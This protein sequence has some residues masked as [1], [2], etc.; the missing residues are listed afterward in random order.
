MSWLKAR[1]FTLESP[2][3]RPRYR[4]AAKACGH[5]H[6]T[7]AR[8]RTQ[9]ATSWGRSSLGRALRWHRRGSRFDPG[10]LHLKWGGRVG[11]A[12]WSPKPAPRG[13]TPRLLASIWSGCALASSL[14]WKASARRKACCGF[15]SRSLRGEGSNVNVTLTL[16]ALDRTDNA[17]LRS[18]LEHRVKVSSPETRPPSTTELRVGS[19]HQDSREYGGVPHFSSGRVGTLASPL[20]SKASAV[21]NGC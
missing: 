20:A 18:Q 11:C 8:I 4:R 7:F 16:C 5:C 15:D 1:S 2:D 6:P 19:A 13:S 9:T 14:A 3:S 12:S 10:R 21:G 17:H